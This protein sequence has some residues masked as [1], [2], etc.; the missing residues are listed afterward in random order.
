VKSPMYLIA[1]LLLIV[2]WS[3]PLLSQQLA[4]PSAVV[5]QLVNFSGKAVDAQGKTISGVAG[6]T[7]AIYKDQYEAA[8]LWMETQNVTAD[9]R[10]NYTAQLGAATASGLPLDLFSTG[11]ARWL[12]VRINGGE[13]Q[14]RVLLLSVPYALKAADAQT[15]GGLPASAFVLAAPS[16]SSGPAVSATSAGG[17]SVS[18]ST[19]TDVTTTGGSANFLPSFNGASTIIDSVVEQT[20][21]G[22]TARIGIGTSTPAAT[23]DVKGS[24]TV[25]G[26]LNLPAASTATASAGSNS[27]GLGLVA[28]TFNSGTSEAANQVFHWFAEPVGNNSAS[29]SATLNLL[30]ATAPNIP[31][32][33]G[34]HIASNGRITFA[35]GQTFPGTGDGTITGVTAGAGLSGGGSSGNITLS[36]DTTKVPQLAAS[37]AFTGNQA[38]NGNL[39][40]TGSLSAGPISASSSS[41]NAAVIATDTLGVGAGVGNSS[42]GT[43]VY[44][45]GSQYGVY[46]N[47]NAGPGNGSFGVAGYGTTGVYGSGDQ[48]GVFGV[49][50]TT[51]GNVGVYGNAG[52]GVY[53][54]GYEGPGVYAEANTQ[55]WAV[56]A[57]NT[58]SS[59]GVLAGT[60][61]DKAYA[62][63]FSGNVEV[64]GTLS[65]AGGSFKIDHP[66]DP[67]N[68]YLYHSFVESPDMMNIC[69]GNVTLDSNGE[70]VVT[71]PGWFEALN[72]DFRYQ[73]TAVGA[74]GPN[75]YVAEEISENHFKIAGGRPGAK[76]SWQVTGIRQDEWA[77]AHRIPVEQEKPELERGFYLHPEF[78]GAPEEKG[79]LWATA[80]GAMKQWKEA[81]AKAAA[82]EAATTARTISR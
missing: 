70:A 54:V 68:R 27:N 81:R 77:N 73:L 69:N 30:F 18:P 44:G 33:T 2:M 22:S 42:S 26:L 56:D 78:F 76:V 21:S 12:G 50:V 82:R 49:A 51:S 40:A 11:E 80:P 79:I 52:T 13:E 4:T 24:T 29:P 55:G 36:V 63:W 59:T 71:L 10:G 38:V 75:L 20:G 64:D 72:R 58:G 67:A 25:R 57:V 5:P 48:Y 3:G 23:L 43:G 41:T 74:P 39:S 35:P 14:L 28:S 66:L 17:G 53:A 45:S 1:I 47:A 34:L 46:G 31:A 65:K 32:E 9:S 8:P 62:G 7:F 15:L 37:N 60:S 6:V 19:A 61:S 16:V